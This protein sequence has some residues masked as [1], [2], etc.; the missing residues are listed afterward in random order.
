MNETE[1]KNDRL[2][3]F[4]ISLLCGGDVRGTSLL[5]ELTQKRLPREP[6]TAEDVL[7]ALDD[8]SL[9]LPRRQVTLRR[10][11]SV[12]RQVEDWTKQNVDVATA[13]ELSI[14][15]VEGWG[16]GSFFYV[17]G[18]RQV[19]E[20]QRAAVFNSRKPRTISPHDPWLRVSKRFT[21]EAMEQG[22][23]LVSSLGNAPYN[24]ISYLAKRSGSP[25]VLVCDGLLPWMDS[26][27][28]KDAF[29]TAYG[30]LFDPANT[31]FLSPFSPGFLPPY[32][33]RQPIRDACV[34]TISHKLWVAEVRPNG[35][36]ERLVKRAAGRGLS[37]VQ[38]SPEK[39][40]KAAPAALTEKSARTPQTRPYEVLTMEDGQFL[41]HF[42]RSCPGP[43]PGQTWFQYLRSLDEEDEHSGHSAFDTL[44]RILDKKTIRGGS[45]LTRGPGRVVSFTGCSLR[46]M[47]SLLRW[48]RSLIRWNFEPY[49]IAVNKELLQEMGARPVVYAPSEEYDGLPEA[50]QYRFQLHNPPRTDW[51]GEKE[52]RIQGDLDLRAVPAGQM[53]IVIP[54]EALDRWLETPHSFPIV[55]I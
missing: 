7:Q 18:N 32:K 21:E 39:I 35:I 12:M 46:E 25:L 9:P 30:D 53:A 22:Y 14:C 33:E 6:L 23:V 49:G 28:K 4:I 47:R 48:N 43:W 31:L 37:I 13:E 27:N 55:F 34:A 16:L 54:K 52:W 42:T 51:S 15:D 17:W 5:T 26:E 20:K 8:L 36:M 40:G 19:L 41:V 45:R 11:K 50:E 10:I 29:L 1:I 38:A 44:I 3:L 2:M 24:W